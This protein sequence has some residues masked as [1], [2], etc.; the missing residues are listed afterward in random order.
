[1]SMAVRSLLAGAF[2]DF[3][4]SWPQLVVTDLV[5]RITAVVLIAPAVGLLIE[6]FLRRTSTRVVTDE[7]IVSFLL[8]PFG[9]TALVVVATV[10]LGVL[11][12]ETSQLMVIGF[13]AV[14]ERRVTW[15]DAV[16]YAYR[17]AV[18]LIR[19]AAVAVIKLLL[20]SVPFLT[21]VGGIYWMLVRTHDINY[22][23]ARKPPEFVAAIVAVGSVTVVL[24]VLIVWIV[25]GWLLA[26]PMVLFEGVGGPRSLRNSV[27]VTSSRRPTIALWLFGWLVA[28]ALAG[29]VVT[30]FIGLLGRLIVSGLATNITLLLVGLSIV[31]IFGLAA[32]LAVSVVT[33]VVVPLFVVRLYRSMAGPGELQPEIAPRGTLGSGASLNV[34]GKLVVATGLMVAVSVVVTASLAVEEPDWVDPTQIIAHRGGAWVAP[35]NTMAAFERGIADGADWVELDVQENADGEVVVEH[36]RDFMRSA[37]AKLEVWQATNADLATLDIGSSFASEFS[38]QRVPTLRQVLELAKGK[39]GV[40]IELKYYGHDASLEQKVVDLVE[41]TGMTD[42]IV[43]MSLSYDG[44]R[45]T[46]ALRPEWTYGLL[47]A[48]AV[49][50]LTRL[51]VD[52][53]AP[54]AK[55]TTVP[56]VRRT[57]HRGMKIYPWTINDPVQMWIMMSRGAD[58]IITDRVALANRIR[59][60][61]AEVT[62]VGRFI[63]WMAGE[64]G[65]L[66]GVNEPSPENNA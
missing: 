31:M 19:L 6:L 45:K 2:A 65:L 57:H 43:I 38:D 5:A 25:A 42:D 10:S 48:V 23:L 3:R 37:G 32:N 52:F 1:M 4:R 35:E 58:G 39:A 55:T 34:P 17:R 30:R 51:D 18:G 16:I 44:V 27:T 56:M 7:A 59:T 29:F 49:G 26:L 9:L 47:N 20:L 66:G 22:Y 61:R 15:L 40:F 33:T 8:H 14:E 53:L 41:E 24:A 12:V 36:D 21:L 64:T 54:T 60:L 11:F 62:P 13:G 28:S 63:I 50:D 46:A